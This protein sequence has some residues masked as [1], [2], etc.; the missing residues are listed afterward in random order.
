MNTQ[1]PKTPDNAPEAKTDK[2]ADESTA[3]SAPS[4]F[5]LTP[6][7]GWTVETIESNSSE[8]PGSASWSLAVATRDGDKSE[9]LGIFVSFD[10]GELLSKREWQLTLEQ[11]MAKVRHRVRQVLTARRKPASS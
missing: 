11:E 9:R 5:K 7:T 3:N 1:T 10:T 6:E 2:P 8:S 4:G